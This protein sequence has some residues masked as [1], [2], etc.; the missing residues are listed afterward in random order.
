VISA[1]FTL[2]MSLAAQNRLKIHK[3]TIVMFKGIQGH[4][5]QWQS[6]ARA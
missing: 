4:C 3:T 5:S 2:E 6:K 1:Q